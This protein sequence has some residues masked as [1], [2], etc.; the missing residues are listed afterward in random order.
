MMNN[1]D[2]LVS[3]TIDGDGTLKATTGFGKQP[4]QG[5]PGAN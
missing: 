3:L 4:F 2:T 1:L 5:H